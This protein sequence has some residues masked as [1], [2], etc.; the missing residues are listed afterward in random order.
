[1]SI[2]AICHSRALQ[3]IAIPWVNRK[4]I[5]QLS[6]REISAKYRGSAL[7]LFWIIIAPVLLLAI[8]TLFLGTFLQAKWGNNGMDSLSLCFFLFV[9]LNFY[10]FFAEILNRSP[11]LIRGNSNFVKKIIFPLE[12]LPWVIIT[13]SFFSMGIA[14]LILIIFHFIVVGVIPITSLYLILIM[15]SVS[16]YALAAV[17][18]LSS[19]SVYVKDVSHALTFMITALMFLSPIFYS[20]D[21]MSVTVQK[22]LHLNPLTY[23]IEQARQSFLNGQILF[24]KEYFK[25]TFIGMVLAWLGFEWF[26]KIKVGFADVL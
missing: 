19:L 8:Y 14:F 7:G 12:I 22:F 25:F 5:A 15:I 11:E 24:I 2:D 20:V 21:S 9:G 3:F 17:F 6:K 23:A 1:M 10:N 18:F 13:T 4:L 16:F 26:Q